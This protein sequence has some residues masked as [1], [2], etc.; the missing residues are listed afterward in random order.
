MDCVSTRNISQC[1]PNILYFA[2]VKNTKEI[3]ER[4]MKGDLPC[5]F[6]NPNLVSIVNS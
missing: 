3:L 2:D 4:A 6:L 5:A 1:T